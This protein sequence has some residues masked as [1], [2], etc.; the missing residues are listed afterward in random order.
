MGIKRHTSLGIRSLGS[1]S[2]SAT[3]SVALGELLT[4][5]LFH[6]NITSALG[7]QAAGEKSEPYVNR[8]R[9]K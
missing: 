3:H 2:S 6:A 9:K 7:L 5:Q 1:S 4:S 8:P